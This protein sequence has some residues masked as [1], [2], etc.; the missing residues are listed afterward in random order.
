M[1]NKENRMETLRKAGYNVDNF[2]DLSLRIPLGS[3]VKISVDGKEMVIGQNLENDPIVQNIINDGYVYNPKTDGRFVAAQTFKMLT[4]KSW[5]YKIRQH[6]TGWDAYL[7][8][9]YGFMYQF[10]MMV[11][12]LHK[13]SKMEKDNDP[14][15]DKVNKFFTKQVVYET[16]NHYVR[17]LKKYIKNQPRRKCKGEPY[18]KLNRYGNV[19]VKDLNGKVYNKL[20]YALCVI[21]DTKTYA[22]LEDALK[23]FMSLM[24]KLPYE[25]PKCSA[26]KDAFKGI[27]AYKTLNNIIKHHGVVVQNYETKAMLDRD[28][29]I[30]YID[31]LLDTYAGAYWKYHELLKAT[32][33]LN[34]FDLEKS[35]DAQRN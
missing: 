15:F 17:Q 16:C 8:N 11:D 32:I 13:L 6:E 19:F 20:I 33:E 12:E 5:N 21:N 34:N 9:C 31:S 28:G 7:R 3:T 1:M 35:I 10:E 4:E 14:D 22:G 27:G 25:T 29:S 2:F 30:A 24:V 26:W 23:Y 18:V